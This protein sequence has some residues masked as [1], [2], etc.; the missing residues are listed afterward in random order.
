AEAEHADSSAPELHVHLGAS[1]RSRL[2][3][4]RSLRSDRSSAHPMPAPRN[5]CQMFSV[6]P[7]GCGMLLKGDAVAHSIPK[8]PDSRARAGSRYGMHFVVTTRFIPPS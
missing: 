5:R 1:G 2:R 8:P 7:S 6:G 4:A 3:G